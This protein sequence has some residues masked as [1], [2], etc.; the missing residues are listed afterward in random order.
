MI[1][2][3]KYYLTSMYA[4]G[5]AVLA[6]WLTIFRELFA[7]YVFNDW[8]FFRFLFV[9]IVADTVFAMWKIVRKEGWRALS[10]KEANGLLVKCFLYFGVL[11]LAHSLGNFTI[12]GKPFTYFTWI[13]YFL[14]SYMIAKEAMSVAKNINA[15]KPDWVPKWVIE[16]LDKFQ[17]TGKLEDLAKDKDE[18]PKPQEPQL[19][20]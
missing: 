14:Y 16:R 4:K 6:I 10:F 15:I 8:E 17:Q 12:H 3:L 13:D 2:L 5:Y 20:S 11:V 9:L 1:S 19:N 18:P 7:K